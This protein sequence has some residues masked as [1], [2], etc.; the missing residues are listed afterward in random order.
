[1]SPRVNRILLMIG[2]G[3]DLRA[4]PIFADPGSTSTA[5]FLLR[6]LTGSLGYDYGRALSLRVVILTFYICEPT[7]SFPLPFLI[8]IVRHCERK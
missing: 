1:M 5:D 3:R 7:P 4:R 8:A 6:A 2:R